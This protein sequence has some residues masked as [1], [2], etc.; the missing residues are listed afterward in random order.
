MQQRTLDGYL[1]EE[2][3]E[4]GGRRGRPGIAPSARLHFNGH[5]SVCSRH[6]QPPDRPVPEEREQVE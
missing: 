5:R 4:E 1:V 3:V 6:A 2:Y